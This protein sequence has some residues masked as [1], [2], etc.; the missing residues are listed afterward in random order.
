MFKRI[1]KNIKKHYTIYKH[2]NK[3]YSGAYV[4]VLNKYDTPLMLGGEV[5]TINEWN[6][7]YP[8]KKI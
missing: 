2:V 7:K 8:D 4:P 1:V 6:E 5:M 3:V